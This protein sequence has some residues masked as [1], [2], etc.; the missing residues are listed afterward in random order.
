MLGLLLII[1]LLPF[2]VAIAWTG[3]EIVLALLFAT[4]DFCGLINYKDEPTAA[5]TA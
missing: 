5:S 3:L 2:A 1:V 4:L